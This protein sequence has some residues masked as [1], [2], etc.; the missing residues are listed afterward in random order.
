MEASQQKINR[1]IPESYMHITYEVQILLIQ[2]RKKL[3]HLVQ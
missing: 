2:M 1:V 3:I